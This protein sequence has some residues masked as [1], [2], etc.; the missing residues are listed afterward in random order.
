ML[1]QHNCHTSQ[2][3][4]ADVPRVPSHRPRA[5]DESRRSRLTCKLYVFVSTCRLKQCVALNRI[6]GVCTRLRVPR[7]CEGENCYSCSFCTS[8]AGDW[9]PTSRILQLLGSLCPQA[10][11]SRYRSTPLLSGLTFTRHTIVERYP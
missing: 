6:N 4:W 8:G 2:I 9:L 7:V 3:C 11:Q 10:R 1:R 5:H